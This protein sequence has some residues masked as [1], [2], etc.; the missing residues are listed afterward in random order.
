MDN[1]VILKKVDSD[2]DVESLRNIRNQCRSFMTRNSK[3][4][5]KEEQVKWFGQLSDDVLVYLLHVVEYGVVAYPIGYGL[6]RKDDDCILISGG[7]V[8]SERGKGF[9]SCLFSYLIENAKKFKLPI[10]LEVLKNN[11]RA[12]AIY[13]KLGF[14]V[15]SDDGKVITMEYHYDSSI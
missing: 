6:L 12:F 3:E 5:S 8:E 7:L 11:I 4:I 15:I 1:P 9:G 2:S 10:K 14:R 13:S